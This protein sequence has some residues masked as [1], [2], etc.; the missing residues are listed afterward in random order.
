MFVKIYRQ[1]RDISY[2][3]IPKL[4]Y[5]KMSIFYSFKLDSISLYFELEYIVNNSPILLIPKIL[6]FL[7]IGREL[8]LCVTIYIYEA[9]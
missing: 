4:L 1:K 7:C 6:K 5:F 8:N 2:Y 9:K 3:N